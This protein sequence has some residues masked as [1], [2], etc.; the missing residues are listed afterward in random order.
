MLGAALVSCIG[1]TQK[2][3]A[4]TIIGGSGLLTHGDELK[5]EKQLG[6]GSLT[7]TNIFS[8]TPGD[9]NNSADA[10]HD[11][12]DDKGRTFVIL[13]VDVGSR[14][15]GE[16]KEKKHPEE[17]HQIIAGYNPLS[18]DDEGGFNTPK[19]RNGFLYN[20]SSGLIQTQTGKDQ[21]WN[22]DEDG[23]IFGGPSPS[24]A[25]IVV[26]DDL[27][28]VSAT[29]FAYGPNGFEGDRED[30]GEGGN[31]TNIFGHSGT[32]TFSLDRVDVFTIADAVPEPSSIGLIILAG[33]CA[34][35]RRK[36][37]A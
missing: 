21:T 14:L 30:G 33:L 23:P 18:W 4:G 22:L 3:E 1:L 19:Q 15:V 17:I 6:E 31:G 2:A 29:H 20:L 34:I 10:F 32:T 25:D 28:S 11:A 7:L 5:L 9:H 24:Q 13:E 27:G 12:A 26:S 35:R 36:A 8:H 16:G 37:H